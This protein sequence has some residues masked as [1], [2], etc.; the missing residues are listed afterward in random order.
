MLFDCLDASTRSRI[1]VTTR[2]QARV[3]R[4]L[5]FQLGL[6]EASTAVALMFEVAGMSHVTPPV[7]PH[8]LRGR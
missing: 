5:E 6:L 3:P 4:A 1:V 8:R 7:R 2:I